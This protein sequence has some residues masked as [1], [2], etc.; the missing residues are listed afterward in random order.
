MVFFTTPPGD[1]GV[2]LWWR[3]TESSSE[4]GPEAVSFATAELG[5]LVSADECLELLTASGHR[6]HPHQEHC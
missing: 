4:A 1:F 3:A 2:Q 5:G 6:V